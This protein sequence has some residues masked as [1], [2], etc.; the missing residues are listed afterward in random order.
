MGKRER[1]LQVCN[2]VLKRGG[3]GFDAIF[4]AD[5]LQSDE[6]SPS[7]KEESCLHTE[8]VDNRSNVRHGVSADPD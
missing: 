2:F 1:A 8:G 5:C 7:S 3:L 6:C 4:Y